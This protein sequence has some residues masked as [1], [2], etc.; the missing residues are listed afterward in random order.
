MI[1]D[2][3]ILKKL[4]GIKEIPTL[5]EVMQEVLDAVAS[6]DSAAGDLAAILSK[7]QALCSKVLKIANSAFFAQSRRIFDISDAVVLLGFDSIAQLML[8]T[9]VFTSFGPLGSYE[10][11]DVYGFW[12]HSI[13][14]AMAGKLIAQKVD[15]SPNNNV[16]YFAGL[17]HDI[18]KLVLVTHFASQYSTVL[19]TAESEDLFLHE[20][21]KLVLGF[22]HCD[23]SEWV[24]DRWNFPEELVHARR[25]AGL[26]IS[27]PDGLFLFLSR[28][29]NY[30]NGISMVL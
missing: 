21:E 1:S 6:D 12:K 20:A 13:A 10:K 4:A 25:N 9:T 2:P 7:D 16:I 18:G 8:A 5:P 17:L 29:M 15:E 14:T 24:C 30:L 22:T 3:A 28:E 23:I 19:E 11:F 27:F 26:R